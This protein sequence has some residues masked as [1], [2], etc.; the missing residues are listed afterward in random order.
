M[1]RS[2]LCKN[3]LCEN[4]YLIVYCILNSILFCTRACISMSPQ[5]WRSKWLKIS[6]SCW[7]VQYIKV[8]Q[9][10]NIRII[11]Q[12]LQSVLIHLA[13]LCS[14][15]LTLNLCSSSED[16]ASMFE[17]FRVINLI[18][19]K[20]GCFRIRSSSSSQISRMQQSQKPTL[21]HL[22]QQVPVRR[23]AA[24]ES[25]W[26]NCVLYCMIT[27]IEYHEDYWQKQ[28]AITKIRK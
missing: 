21:S 5:V 16:S 8:A 7:L 13:V 11:Q 17:S 15:L 10:K 18:S 1:C 6:S 14:T 24:L 22:H 28:P 4:T 12:I 26:T 23:C 25:I 19:L 9:N 27:Y 3:S 20:L 2:S